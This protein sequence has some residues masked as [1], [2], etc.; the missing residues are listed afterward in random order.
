LQSLAVKYGGLPASGFKDA[1]GD[2]DPTTL[3]LARRNQFSDVSRVNRSYGEGVEA[4]KR[5]L[6]AR[7]A[8]QSGDLQYA[9][10]Q[11]DYSR[12]GAEYDLGNQF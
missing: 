2:V 12:A 7:G 1:Y 11:A 9:L 3:D 4:S 8:L 6:A 10:D 5:Q